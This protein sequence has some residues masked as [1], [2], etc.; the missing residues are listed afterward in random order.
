MSVLQQICK[1]KDSERIW[2][3]VSNFN[4]RRLGSSAN[5]QVHW[6]RLQTFIIIQPRYVEKRVLVLLPFCVAII[7][8]KIVL[9]VSKESWYFSAL[10]VQLPY[11]ASHFLERYFIFKIS[12]HILLWKSFSKLSVLV[13]LWKEEFHI[14]LQVHAIV[15]FPF[16]KF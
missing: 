7:E 2:I 8:R 9:Y 1:I 3:G 11:L 15:I 10:L 4:R 16:V 5:T 6:I 13:C 14:F 12:F